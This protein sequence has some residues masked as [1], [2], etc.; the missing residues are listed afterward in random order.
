MMQMEA[1]ATRLASR[2]TATRTEAD[3]QSDIKVLLLTADLDL[4]DDDIEVKLEA[5]AGQQR[6]IDIEVGYTVIETK[7]NL[8][9]AGVL[10]DAVNQLE[11]YVRHRTESTGQRYVG[12]VTDGHDWH[13][14]TLNRDDTL[15]GAG[16]FELRTAEDT[17][18]LLSWLSAILATTHNVAA[19][20]EE[21]DKKFGSSSPAHDLDMIALREL[22]DGNE[23]NGELRLKKELWGKLLHTALGE[24]FTDEVSL[25]IEHTYLVIT[26]ELIAHEVLGI[27][28]TTIEPSS[29]VTGRS[30]IERGVHG[31]VES[32]FFDWP[33]EVPGGDRAIRAI[34][35]RVGQIDW[36][37]TKHDLLK[38][39]Y[40]SVITA[41][42]RHNLGEYYTPDWLAEAVVQEIVDTPST[43][44]VLDPA[45]GSGTFVFHAVR[46]ALAAL[47]AS[48]VQNK[49]AL[50]HVT[51]HVI[52]MDVHPVAVTLARVTYLLALTTARLKGDRGE[53]S[54][55]VYLG[56]S[57]QWQ[58][59]HSVM[60]ADGLTIPTDDGKALL[61]SEL[62][63]PA[64]SLGDPARFDELVTRLVAK[65]TDRERGS[66]I[67]AVKQLLNGYGLNERDQ[68]ALTATFH[69]LCV[70]HD[71]HRNHIWGY[72]VKNLARPVWLTRDEGKVHRIVG[73]PPWLSYRFMDDRTKQA[74]RDRCTQRNIW[75]G[76]RLATQQDLAAY[77]LVRACELYLKDGEQFGM[78]VP[79]ATLSRKP[80][81]GFRA[82][83]WGV[84]G[85]AEFEKAWDLDQVRPH[86]FPVPSA[87][88]IGRFRSSE[89]APTATP[90]KGATEKWKGTIKPSDSWATAQKK[91]IRSEATPGLSTADGFA[92]PYSERFLQ[93]ATVTPR[94]L[95]VVEQVE[96]AGG[97]GLPSGVV[98]VRSVR[99]KMEKGV[100]KEQPSR[101][102]VPVET[103]MLHPM[104]LGSTLL[105]YRMT[106]P[107]EVVLPIDP[108][109]GK[110]LDA[111]DPALDQYPRA[112]AWWKEGIKIWDKFGKNTM[113][114]MDRVDYQSTLKAQFP[115]APIRLVYTKSGN[116]IAAAVVTD[117]TAVIDHT[118]Y[119]GALTSVE[120]ARYLETILNAAVTQRLV[121]PLQSRGLLGARH[122]DMYPW[123]LPIP[124]F[125]PSSELHAT[126]A[127]QGQV[128]EMAAAEVP[129]APGLAFQSARKRIRET[130]MKEGIATT[131][132]ATVAK[133]LGVEPT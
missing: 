65:A 14:F 66:K 117:D 133:L 58:I 6:R 56:D 102:P 42:Q 37:N 129:L 47:E 131:I 40:E 114:L 85:T 104:H 24:A 20:P 18:R 125:N 106:R 82:A 107:W 21:I 128:A 22:W 4:D 50:D 17:E 93:G 7:R 111:A 116:R 115:A 67:P 77:F 32:D 8:R 26:A 12:I 112:A 91:L 83:I 39:L 64:A 45:C 84:A 121:E 16:S 87:V 29:L 99:S 100:W 2:G 61:S 5:Q 34:A 79:F 10:D 88:L 43:Q 108:T 118:L 3:I 130:L 48:G 15:L 94:V 25:F 80:S 60:N 113:S 126:L 23:N 97:L 132:E 59:V 70:L 63:F 31:V 38:H 101:G 78:V 53:I 1:L 124:R 27:D 9:K 28:I 81:E 95:H 74:F 35:R 11:G 71:Q 86:I 41:E 120:E 76:G 33:A 62:F 19:T 110:V 54:V 73:N 69:E 13:L 75:V 52:G 51:T 92:S 46:R 109:N 36:S 98:T 44:R 72:Y 49:E 89:S 55:P 68:T 105:P 96:G 127:E 30:F 103:S 122:F 123:Y 119:W 57:V 90:L